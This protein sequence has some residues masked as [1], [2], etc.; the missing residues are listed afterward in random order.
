[1]IRR[2]S[3]YEFFYCICWFLLPAFAF[4]MA[5]IGLRS[6]G[7]IQPLTYDYI[8]VCVTLSLLWIVFSLYFLVTRIE[9]LFL[10][11]DGAWKCLKTISGTY[12][13][14]FSLLFF[15]RGA[16]YS[17]LLLCI[18]LLI[19]VVA[20][21][22][23]RKL[24]RYMVQHSG[25]Q[26]QRLRIIMIGADDF[27]L[28]I[29]HELRESAVAP[30]E[31]V[32]FVRIPGQTVTVGGEGVPVFELDQIMSRNLKHFANDMV[33]AVSP[34]MLPILSSL[35]GQ[36]KGL[37]IPIRFCMDFGTGVTV[38]ER[39][40]RIGG[41]HMLDVHVAPSETISYIILK[42]CFDIAFSAL[43]L[44]VVGLPMA[45]IALIVKLSSEGPV[46][47]AQERVGINGQVFKMLKFRTM[48][49]A[50]SKES[51]SGWTTPQDARCT[52]LG[53]FLRRS[54][55]DEFPQF[56][57]VMAGDMSV[58][59]PR[60]ERPF[61]VE[62]FNDEFSGYNSRHHLKS[63]I[64]GWAQVN[65]MRGD[66]DIG[67]RLELDIYYVKNWSFIFDLRIIFMTVFS[68]LFAQNAY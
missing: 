21:A 30:C 27:A 5:G 40:F 43:M 34:E 36:L 59:G 24:V 45:V 47:F 52:K 42:R 48:K 11:A 7:L 25:K 61:F 60:P 12:M 39:F 55:M 56:F 46:F 28:R 1:M 68:G 14:A 3:L 31:T 50:S 38:G 9:S 26:S 29:S 62:K 54:C 17:R 4:V 44:A 18:S 51:N 15:Y 58:V 33:L 41:T 66:T 32:A 63:G 13:S 19:L 49:V 8:L 2:I 10:E 65:G 16:S 64:T 37:A 53:K 20:V 6:L 67:K 22:V 57:N 23:L 35:I